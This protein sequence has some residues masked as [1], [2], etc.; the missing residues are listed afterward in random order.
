MPALLTDAQVDAVRKALESGANQA[1]RDEASS[2]LLDIQASF[3]DD[4]DL[5]RAIRSSGARKRGDIAR[6]VLEWLRNPR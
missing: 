5:V 6:A 2:G 1:R 3:P 4:I